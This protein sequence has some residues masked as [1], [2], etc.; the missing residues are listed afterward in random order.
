[1]HRCRTHRTRFGASSACRNRRSR[2]VKAFSLLTSNDQWKSQQHYSQGKG[3]T[4]HWA[5]FL[6]ALAPIRGNVVLKWLAR[7]PAFQSQAINHN[8]RYVLVHHLSFRKGIQHHA[9]HDVLQLFSLLLSSGQFRR[10]VCF[11]HTYIFRLSTIWIA[12]TPVVFLLQLKKLNVL[13]TCAQRSA[14]R[15]K[16]LLK[17]RMKCINYSQQICAHYVST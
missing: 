1:M 6:Y 15:R 14:R 8:T 2:Y 3:G 9:C 5:Q 13:T 4:R 7:L 10:Y 16:I 17:T 11:A 12:R